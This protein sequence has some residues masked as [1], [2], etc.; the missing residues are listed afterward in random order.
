MAEM[1][2][3]RPYTLKD[4]L[5]AS[6]DVKYAHGEHEK[7]VLEVN[8]HKKAL[9]DAEKIEAEKALELANKKKNLFKVMATVDKS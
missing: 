6:D 8:R 2:P 5:N 4:L 9:A 7:A 1:N 3:N